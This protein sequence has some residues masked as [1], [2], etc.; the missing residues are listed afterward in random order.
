MIFFI[1]FVHGT[2]GQILHFQI[3]CLAR[4]SLLLRIVELTKNNQ[5]NRFQECTH[6]TDIRSHYTTEIEWLMDMVYLHKQFTGLDGTGAFYS[7]IS[8]FQLH[9]FAALRSV[10]AQIDKREKYQIYLNYWFIYLRSTV[11][12]INSAV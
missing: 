6:T 1:H 2:L 8:A 9:Y 7:M 11:Y 4:T 3:L 10:C 5:S 12:S